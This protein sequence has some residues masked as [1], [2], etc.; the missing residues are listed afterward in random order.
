MQ[1]YY[2]LTRDGIAGAIRLAHRA[3]ELDPRFGSVAS[4]A[5]SCYATNVILGYAVDP[6]FDRKEAVRLARLALSI[7]DGDPEILAWA[8]A[9]SAFMVG[10]A[11]RET[12]MADRAVVLNPNSSTAWHG[13]GHVYRIAGLPEEAVR[14]Y[15]RAMRMSPVDPAQYVVLVGMGMAFIELR[16]FDEAIAAGKKAVRQKPSFSMAYHC[17]TGAFA[18]LGCDAEARASARLLQ[19]DPGFTISAWTTIKREAAD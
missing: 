6:Q 16:R 17:L 9:T 2:P 19:V 3:L 14:S 1:Q 8:A 7:D 10:D 18:H 11:E 4:L 15:E 12:E 5:G 13:R